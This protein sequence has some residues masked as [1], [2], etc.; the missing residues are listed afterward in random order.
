[1]LVEGY[2]RG[3]TNGGPG[4]DGIDDLS[5]VDKNVWDEDLTMRST[6]DEDLKK[7]AK[8]WKMGFDMLDKHGKQRGVKECD[9]LRV[10]RW[11]TRTRDAT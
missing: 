2:G 3:I 8:E 11:K 4:I 5:V 1:M 9:I 7:I 6:T 10:V